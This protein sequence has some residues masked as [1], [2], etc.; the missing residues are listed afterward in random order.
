MTK[1]KTL[2]S[3]S[4][5]KSNYFQTLL[6]NYMPSV[7]EISQNE[8]E[9]TMLQ[10]RRAN[11]A[12]GSEY[13]EEQRKN[14]CKVIDNV[15]DKLVKTQ[16]RLYKSRSEAEDIVSRLPSA[17]ATVLRMRYFLGKSWNAIEREMCEKDEKF[18]RSKMFKMHKKALARGEG[19]AAHMHKA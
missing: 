11:I 7:C 1:K 18:T 5:D 10:V 9:L 2:K 16:E 4:N 12:S 14:L 19:I 6:E 8:K 17:L 13:A 15:C 3:Q